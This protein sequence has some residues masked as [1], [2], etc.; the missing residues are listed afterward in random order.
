MTA[1]LNFVFQVQMLQQQVSVLA[2]NQT[3]T[4]DRYTRASR[5]VRPFRL[6]CTCW[7][8]SF[9]SRSF[10]LRN[11]CRRRRRGIES[12]LCA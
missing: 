5:T 4:D 10:E 12:L 7:K 6:E 9:E 2:D 3:N 8:S 11:V 1:F